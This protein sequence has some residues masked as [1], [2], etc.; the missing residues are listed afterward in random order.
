MTY[1]DLIKL[2]GRRTGPLGLV[3]SSD[4]AMSAG[5]QWTSLENSRL[6]AW[7]VNF[8][9]GNTNN[10]N[11]YN[12]Y[13]VRPVAALNHEIM[14]GWTEAFEDC[15]RHKMTTLQCTLYRISAEDDLPS[16]AEEVESRTYKPSTST[17]FVVSHPV[18]REIFAAN[19]RDRIVQHWICLRLNPL[20]EERFQ[21]M[22]NVS[23]NCRVGYGVL[24]AV[25]RIRDEILA[26]SQNYT[27]ETWVAKI[28][29]RSCFNSIDKSIL[30]RKLEWLI[31]NH[32][33]G[34]D[35]EKLKWVTHVTLMHVPEA[36]CVKRGRLE[37]WNELNPKKSRF[38]L[39]PDV[40]MPI[41]N[42]TSQLFCG[43][44]LS[45]LDEFVIP[46]V[47]RFGGRYIRF[48]DDMTLVANRK[49]DLLETVSLIRTFLRDELNLQLHPDKVYI[50]P[51][52][53]GLP[54]VGSVIK[55]GRIYI[56]N[57]TVH[58]MKK[59]MN[60]TERY[61]STIL[62]NG[63]TVRRAQVLQTLIDGLNSYLGIVKHSASRNLKMKLFSGLVSF[64]KICYVKN[65]QVVKI[66]K[67]F[68]TL[69]L[70]KQHEYEEDKQLRA[71]AAHYLA[72]PSQTAPHHRGHRRGKDRRRLQLQ[73]GNP[74]ARH[75]Q[76]RRHRQRPDHMQVPV[77]QDAG[78]HQQ[79]P[80]RPF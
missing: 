30:W 52:K 59:K 37:L 65:L 66:R 25:E 75:D 60:Q 50:Q 27:K 13:G 45:F 51:A 10:N 72:Q 57:R 56:S 17:C 67:P 3:I 61:C 34:D 54:V 14:T 35:K 44:F 19:F 70:L 39:P 41:G 46:L 49:E 47:R 16:L 79:L 29:I 69:T 18:L 31:D 21:S 78:H 62:A 48:V 74:S 55:P 7:Y 71:Q 36:D 42:I 4:G 43:F 2:N 58:N 68:Q 33:H 53:K 15:C 26:V 20:F 1:C 77:G 76:L 23:Y 9:N 32:Y 5:N 8:G 28:D 40:G 73:G 11:K 22:G 12:A 80:R 63:I 64:W 38:N 6:N 24:A